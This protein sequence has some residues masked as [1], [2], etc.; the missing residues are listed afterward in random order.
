M[1]VMDG[2]AAVGDLRRRY[3]GDTYAE[4]KAT[5]ERPVPGRA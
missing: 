3:G 5:L 4:A 1:I 2:P